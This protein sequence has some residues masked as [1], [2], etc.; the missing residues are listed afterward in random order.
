M[1]LPYNYTIHD[2]RSKKDFKGI[3]ICGYKRRDVIN[4]FQ[5]SIINNKL[6]DS[7]RWCVE[8]HC[9]GLNNQIWDSFENVYIKYVHVNNPKLFFY[10]LKRKKDYM[11]IIKKYSKQHE[12]FTRNNQEIRNL[13]AELTS[14]LTNTQKNNIF[15]EK[16]LPSIKKDLFDGIELK[17]RMISKNLDNIH[18]Y[19]YNKTTN[20]VKL[21]LNEIVNN[22]LSVNG[23]FKNCIYWYIWLT[24]IEKINKKKYNEEEYIYHWTYIL[25]K[26]LLDFE[27]KLDKNNIIFLKKM[28]YIYKKDFKIN[29]IARKKYYFFIS[30]YT[31]K[32][33]INWNINLFQQEYLIIQTNS[34]INSMY[35]SI[36]DSIE[37][38]ISEQSRNILSKNYYKLYMNSINKVKKI[39]RVMK[40]YLDEDINKVM[41]TYNPEYKDI[42]KRTEMLIE[43][44]IEHILNRNDNRLISKN[45][46][47]RDII[48]EKEELKKKKLEAF[49]NFV[50]YKKEG[51]KEEIEKSVIDY[52]D[53][54]FSKRK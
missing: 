37:K 5:N 45:M 15:I 49:T 24:K 52:K 10:I 44:P 38:N 30:F 9:T 35:K 2:T 53:I 14:I 13:Y 39:K 26:I 21:G 41:F 33:N 36:I 46:T 51:Q 16:S 17:K 4:T 6:E 11:N 8:L 32:N 20:E 19:I 18:Q 54:I 47:E 3:T 28:E 43:E 29:S 12:I 48:N 25:W 7:I 50:T 31:I 1:E 34:N 27:D 40:T 22:L 23:T 42:Q